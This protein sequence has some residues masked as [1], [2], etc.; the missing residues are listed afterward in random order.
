[1]DDLLAYSNNIYSQQGEDGILGRIFELIP[2]K[3]RWCVE[4]GALNGIHHSNTRHLIADLGWS[5]VLIEPDQTYYEKW[6]QV[7]ADT[8]RVHT[9][10]AFVD[11]SSE[12]SLGAELSRTPIPKDFDL[13]S[14]DID[15]NDYHVWESLTEYQPRVVVVEYNPSIP[16]DISFIQARDMSVQQGSSARATVEL[17]ERK[18]YTLCAVA[19][20]NL[21]FVRN[22]LFAS[23]CLPKRTLAELNTDTRYLTR[24]YQLYDG[25]LVLDGCQR[26]LWHGLP[27]DAERI[28]VV[29]RHK[30]RY[31]AG[32]SKS[33]AVRTLKYWVRRLPMYNFLQ[34]IRRSV[35]L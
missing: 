30:R 27:I 31:V 22:E 13:L 26:L 6:E 3:N 25:T 18:G 4:L 14:L 21:F 19:G 32:T 2:P 33:S 20:V 5:G 7:Y 28:Q 9:V 24:L 15:G 8:P 23:L 11:F 35:G 17:G 29:P 34:K 16:N 1:M 10:N 12:H